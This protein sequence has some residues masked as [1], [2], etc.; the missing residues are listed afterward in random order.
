MRGT[1]TT[2]F[3]M[4][5]LQSCAARQLASDAGTGAGT[6]GSAAS[7][8][9]VGTLLDAGVGAGPRPPFPATI[10]CP[11][12]TEPNTLALVKAARQSPPWV[13]VN[14]SVLLQDPDPPGWETPFQTASDAERPQLIA[15]RMQRL[16][17]SQDALQ[18]RLEAIGA[19]SIS[20]LWLANEVSATVESGFVPE[21]PCWPGVIEVDG[22]AYAGYCT[23]QPYAPGVTGD[24][25]FECPITAG[26]DSCPA[27]CVGLVGAEL[28]RG[29]GGPPTCQESGVLFV[30]GQPGSVDPVGSDEL[31]CYVRKSDGAVFVVRV[32]FLDQ[33]AFAVRPCTAQEGGSVRPQELDACP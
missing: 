26:G 27:G 31:T 10:D 6:D 17:P 18:A 22:D 8:R 16:A 20:R 1:C 13:E 15:Q 7:D 29:A 30:C 5:L 21:I 9:F 14:V 25:V 4:V 2:A 23:P 32:P 19:R 28:L 11:L 24:C 3:L 33:Q 12:P